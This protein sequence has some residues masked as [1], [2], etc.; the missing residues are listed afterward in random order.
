MLRVREFSRFQKNMSRTRRFP[1]FIESF[2]FT[3][4]DSAIFESYRKR[5]LREFRLLR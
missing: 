3:G 4:I 1:R 5:L 2:D